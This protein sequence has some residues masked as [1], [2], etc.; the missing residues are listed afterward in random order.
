MTGFD[1]SLC[2]LASC[3]NAAEWGLLVVVAPG[4]RVLLLAGFLGTWL[5]LVVQPHTLLGH[6]ANSAAIARV[7]GLVVC[8]FIA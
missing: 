1:R 6:N 2:W 5:R 4:V 3:A 7:L 8:A